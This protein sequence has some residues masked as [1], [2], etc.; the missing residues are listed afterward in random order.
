MYVAEIAENSYEIEQDFRTLIRAGEIA[1]DEKRLKKVQEFAKKQ[2][3]ALDNVLNT[4]YLKSI[5]IGR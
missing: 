2:K 4:D 3:E 5:G 1:E